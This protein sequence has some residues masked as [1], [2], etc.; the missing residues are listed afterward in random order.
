MKPPKLITDSAVQAEWWAKQGVLYFVGAGTPL[1]AVKI[2]VTAVPVGWTALQ[3][4]RTRIKKMQGANH[5]RLSLLGM[6]HIASGDRPMRDT[7]I[8]ERE[9]HMMFAEEQRHTR[10]YAGAEWFNPSERLV[11]YIA[12]H[13][14]MPEHPLG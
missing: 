12:D 5:E 9:L 6:I 8:L 11:A 10:H 14:E 2:G 7:E 4:A 1:I 3:A 13:A